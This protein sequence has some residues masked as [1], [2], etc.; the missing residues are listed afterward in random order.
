MS[1]IGGPEPLVS[2]VV[3]VYDEQEGLPELRRRVTAALAGV[4]GGYEVVLV[5][6]GSRDRSAELIEEWAAAD[7]RVVLVQL[8]RNF[9]M[10]IAMTAGL[11][12]ARGRYT[13][14]MHADLQDPPELIPEMLALAARE[15]ADVVFARRIG[16]GSSTPS[17]AS[18]IR[19]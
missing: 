17:P 19:S 2:V 1:D 11:D 5:D 6:D 7:E 18:S 8:S 12:Y 15:N 14:I 3:P 9:G 4:D 16:A 10:E 13:A